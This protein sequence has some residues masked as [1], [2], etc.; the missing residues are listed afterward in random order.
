MTLID[1]NKLLI[2]TDQPD[3]TAALPS[4]II[5]GRETYVARA[6]RSPRASWNGVMAG[7][8]KH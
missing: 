3:T 1:R 4:D 8:V 7:P 5:F 6:E 2:I